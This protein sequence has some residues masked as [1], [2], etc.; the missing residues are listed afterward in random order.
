[1]RFLS[2]R[3][4]R[5]QSAQIWRELARDK[6]MVVTRNGRPIAILTAVDENTFEKSLEA[7]RRARFLQTITSIQMES[8]RKGTDSITM[9]EIDAE[10]QKVRR[11]RRKTAR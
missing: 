5:S 1:M 6:E 8:V 9:D 2:V 10:I 7:W 11:A 3:D 4:L